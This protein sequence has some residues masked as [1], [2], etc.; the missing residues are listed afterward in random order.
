MV[1][2]KKPATLKDLIAPEHL[3]QAI[4]NSL[5]HCAETAHGVTGLHFEKY[6]ITVH[7]KKGLR[8]YIECKFKPGPRRYDAEHDK[9]DHSSH[10]R[11][12]DQR[13]A[14]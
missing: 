6:T 2:D 3:L 13:K 12:Q 10:D 4:D 9:E 5:M 14:S 7:K 8:W 11:S 1:R